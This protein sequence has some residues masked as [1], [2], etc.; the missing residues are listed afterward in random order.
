[1]HKHQLA[2]ALAACFLTASCTP[3]SEQYPGTWTTSNYDVRRALDESKVWC[4]RY[5]AKEHRDGD[6][7][8]VY[9]TNDDGRNWAPFRVSGDPFWSARPAPEP[10]E[11]LPPP[12]PRR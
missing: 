7:W 10:F 8:L 12:S 4:E 11:G 9:C 2:I 3:L 5:R 6:A 1:M